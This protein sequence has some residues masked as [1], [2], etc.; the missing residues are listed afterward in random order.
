MTVFKSS[1]LSAD[2]L[3]KV[4]KVHPFISLTPELGPG[5]AS[6]A[7]ARPELVHGDRFY[8]LALHYLLST[9]LWSHIQNSSMSSDCGCALEDLR[10]RPKLSFVP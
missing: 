5:P 10:P 7:V 4:L 3:K 9:S 8:L 6:T 1:C 2:R